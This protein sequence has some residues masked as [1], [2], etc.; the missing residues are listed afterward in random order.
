MG[1]GEEESKRL[2]TR[3]PAQ[4]KT[5]SG[6]ATKKLRGRCALVVVSAQGK[7]SLGTARQLSHKQPSQVHH[8]VQVFKKM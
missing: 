2:T 3:L 8:L 7:F 6:L 1:R 5:K 4:L